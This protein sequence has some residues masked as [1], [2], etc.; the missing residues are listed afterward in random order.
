[1][2]NSPDGIYEK[3]VID[4][5][6]PV[7]RS[8]KSYW[9]TEPAAISKLQSPWLKSADIVIIGSGMTAASLAYKL[10]SLR[11]DLKII[12][13]EARD[14]CGGATGRNGGHVKPMSPGVWFDRKEQFGAQEAIRIMEYE[15]GHVDEIITCIREND[16]ACDFNL[17]QGLDIYYDP[18]AFQH[19]LDAVEDM[20]KYA[21]DLGKRYTIYT[22]EKDLEARDCPKQCIGAIG[23]RAASMWPY[24]L[25]TAYGSKDYDY[26]MQRP[27]GAFIVGRANTGR[28]ASSDDS[29]VDWLPHVHLRTVTHQAFDFGTDQVET[30]HAWSGAV[31]FIVDGNPFVGRLPFPGRDHQWVS[32]AYQ[33]IGMV[34]AFRSAQGLA[35]LIIGEQL[36]SDFPRSMLLTESRLRAWEKEIK[37]KI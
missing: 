33:G 21:P 1:M 36:P 30:T 13:I 9:L 17:L 3:G 11:S 6:L 15:H 14:I 25:V 24:K 8:T 32:A 20:K 23:T 28:R 2:S 37:S 7:K 18:K 26:I 29:T 19:A 10:Y 31:G 22:A 12:I 27:D 34:R 5:G 35:H 4:P 16:I